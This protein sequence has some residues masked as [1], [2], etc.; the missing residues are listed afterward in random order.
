MRSCACVAPAL[1]AASPCCSAGSP[2]AGCC[3]HTLHIRAPSTRAGKWW[4]CWSRRAFPAA[5]SFGTLMRRARSCART[6]WWSWCRATS[7]PTAAWQ[8]QRVRPAAWPR[9]PAHMLQRTPHT[10]AAARRPGDANALI[11][12]TGATERLD[13]LGPFNVDFQVSVRAA[14]TFA[15]PHLH[16]QC[17]FCI[18]LDVWTCGVHQAALGAHLHL[19]THML[20]HTR[21]LRATS[22]C[23]PC[24]GSS[25]SRSSCWS[26]ALVPTI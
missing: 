17:K 26:A 13:P 12:A 24:R 23:W 22:T 15:T 14:R 6:R 7:R 4:T 25:A 11:C 18:H 5:H 19:H 20:A 2:A 21:T 3:L 16:L 8:R 1:Q 9:R 10:P